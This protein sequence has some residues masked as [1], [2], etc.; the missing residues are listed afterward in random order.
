[1]CV[2]VFVCLFVYLFVCLFVCLFSCM[3]VCVGKTMY[4][5]MFISTFGCFVN[6]VNLC[7]CVCSLAELVVLSIFIEHILEATT[8]DLNYA[9]MY[10]IS[11]KVHCVNL[12]AFREYFELVRTSV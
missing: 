12:D 7:M 6:Y 3:H 1:M 9:I 11:H 10:Y 2:C 4:V 8:Y 5:C